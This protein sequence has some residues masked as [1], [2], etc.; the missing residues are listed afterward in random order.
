MKHTRSA[1][2][3]HQSLRR[4]AYVRASTRADWRSVLEQRD[5]KRAARR[6]SMARR[7]ARRQLGH[8]SRTLLL[9]LILSCALAL[10]ASAWDAAQRAASALV[11]HQV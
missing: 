2:D 5:A 3:A 10:G 6:E 7:A 11:S 1:Y 9:C 4:A 8:V